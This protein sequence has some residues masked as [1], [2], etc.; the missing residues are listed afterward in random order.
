MIVDALQRLGATRFPITEFTVT[1]FGS[2][3]FIDFILFHK[4]L[5]LRTLLSLEREESL[6][7]RVEV[8]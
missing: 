3:Y 7:K 1:G 2:I 6:K 8:E 5:G 4:L